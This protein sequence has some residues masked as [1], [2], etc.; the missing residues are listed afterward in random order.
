MLLRVLQVAHWASDMWHVGHRWMQMAKF[1][2]LGRADVLGALLERPG[3]SVRSK[4]PRLQV[5]MFRKL[6]TKILVLCQSQ[7]KNL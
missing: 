3:N 4:N 6:S 1:F 2:V 5:V 7:G